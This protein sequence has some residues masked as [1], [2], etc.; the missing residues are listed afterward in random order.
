M[1]VQHTVIDGL[2]RVTMPVHG[3][4]RGSLQQT[5][6]HGEL[7]DALGREL[8]FVQ[9][10]HSRSR[11]G[12]LRGFHAEPWDKLVYVVRGTAF[13]AVADIRPGSPTL[14]DVATFH[15]GDPPGERCALL[16][17][18]GLANAFLA[19]TEVDYH[20]TVT[21]EWR[22]DVPR[23]AVAYDDPQLGVRWPIEQPLLSAADRDNPTLEQLLARW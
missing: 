5:F 7:A 15:L 23:R 2:Y 22:P 1:T 17:T 21:A 4:E 6:Q 14:G 16:I 3:D 9:A 12:V 8:R 13:C 11:A 18:D 19:L 20:Y 10:N